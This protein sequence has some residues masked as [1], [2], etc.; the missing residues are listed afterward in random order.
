MNQVDEFYGIVRI[1]FLVLGGILI[2]FLLWHPS[3]NDYVS[4]I[5]YNL[6]YQDYQELQQENQEI[7]EDIGKLLIEYY[8]KP[9][10][11]DII[12]ITKYKKGLCALKIVLKE[13]IPLINKLPC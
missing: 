8:G 9:I 1:I 7:K 13:E 10:V 3:Q 12:G 5:D 6:L 4:K 11:W 2:G